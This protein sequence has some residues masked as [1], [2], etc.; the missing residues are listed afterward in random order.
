MTKMNNKVFRGALIVTIFLTIAFF[1]GCAKNADE[2]NGKK[3]GGDNDDKAAKVVGMDICASCHYAQTSLWLAGAHGNLEYSY[4][5]ISLPL[6]ADG[7]PNYL[8]LADDP[9]CA[10]C[11]DPL[12]DGHELTGGYTGDTE[13]PVIGCESCHGG[14]SNHYGIGDIPDP[15]PDNDV[16]GKCHNDSFPDGHLPYHPAGDHINEDYMT[17]PHATSIDPVVSAAVAAEAKAAGVDVEAVC[18]RCHTDEGFRKYYGM[19]PSTS[20]HDEIVTALGTLSPVENA[21]NVQCRTCHD[22]HTADNGDYTRLPASTVAAQNQSSEFN[23]CTACHQLNK[24]DGTVQ[25]DAYHTAN[26]QIITDTHAAVPGD[27]RQNSGVSEVPILYVKKA[28]ENAC[29][30]CHNVHTASTTINEDYRES[31]HGDL[32]GDPWIHYN[33]KD[34]N[35][36]S[37]A[38]GRQACQRC[39]TSTGF[40][41]YVSDPLNYNPA[42]NNFSELIYGTG[43]GTPVDNGQM[44]ALYCWAC[45]SNTQVG[46][47]RNP[48]AVTPSL[49]KQSTPAPANPYKYVDMLN[50]NITFPDIAGSNVCMSCHTGRETGG[51]VWNATGSFTNGSFVNSHYLTAGANVFGLSGFEYNVIN[52][53]LDYAN[54]AEYKHDVI[55]LAGA[56]GTGDKGPCVECHMQT[57]RPHIFKPVEEDEITGDI[58]AVTSTVC[59]NCHGDMNAAELNEEKELYHDA[60][61]AFEK[62]MNLR[63]FYFSPNN[64]YIFKAPYNPA[65]TETGACTANIAVRNWQT[66]GNQPTPG[67]SG[68]AC[69]FS[70]ATCTSPAAIPATVPGTAGT[71]KQNMGAAFNYNMLEHDPGAFVHNNYYAKRLIYDSIDWLD[72]N[73]LDDTTRATLAALDGGVETYKAGACEYLLEDSTCATGGRP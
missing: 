24:A 7:F 32:L 29:S 12:G 35:S 42:N 65:Y 54:P 44:Q 67:W 45:H 52:A 51:N 39:H 15:A 13:R 27:V 6:D 25:T 23:T 8:E 9:S 10:T 41:N 49:V 47:L 5:S 60:M 31:G 19:V 46:I 38:T 58:T 20:T 64:P 36:G 59:I 73:A 56:P 71:G 18:S 17:S 16:C 30:V 14:G 69:C 33:W 55:G 72:N 50:A 66:G 28:D 37:T 61:A 57:P 11:H 2:K 62:Q 70:G 48:G 34:L 4:K 26:E 63:N 3:G 1:L 68:T 22:P 21:D 43:T 53:A 40:K